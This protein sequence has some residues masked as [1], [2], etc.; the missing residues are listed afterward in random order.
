MNRDGTGTGIQPGN[1]DI[2]SSIPDP[3]GQLWYLPT[4]RK[5]WFEAGDMLKVLKTFCG[6]GKF[7]VVSWHILETFCV[8]GSLRLWC[9]WFLVD[10]YVCPTR[11]RNLFNTRPKFVFPN[12]FHPYLWYSC[13]LSIMKSFWQS[14]SGFT[15]NFL[16]S[17]YIIHSTK[18]I[19]KSLIL[20]Y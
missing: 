8:L 18:I 11:T 2:W 6:Y 13:Q 16:S 20:I 17:L 9:K 12:L 4:Q 5:N 3:K 15:K 1:T 14:L 10:F 19:K 7:D